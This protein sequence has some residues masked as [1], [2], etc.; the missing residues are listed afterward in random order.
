MRIIILLRLVILYLLVSSCAAGI[1][2]A[3]LKK[4]IKKVTDNTAN[5][6]SGN[7]KCNPEKK[8][9]FRYGKL[10]VVKVNRL[11]HTLDKMLLNQPLDNEPL[12]ALDL[13]EQTRDITVHIEVNTKDQVL[14]ITDYHNK[15]S[16]FTATIPYTV[17]DGFLYLDNKNIKRKGV[18][19]I[20]YTYSKSQVRIGL[21][22]DNH[23]LV[24][25]SLES[26]GSIFIMSAGSSSDTV[27]E[28]ERLT[29]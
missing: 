2:S 19:F 9:N 3:K 15:A 4:N 12:N 17:K 18:P 23:L 21:S 20:F 8:Y 26:H 25:R 7:Y 16:Q 22:N 5:S 11:Q 14:H 10:S 1:H 13:I 29:D 6:V 24:Q 27:Y 28:F